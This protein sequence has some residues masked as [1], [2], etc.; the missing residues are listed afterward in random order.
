MI[1]HSEHTITQLIIR[2]EHIRLLQAGPTLLIALIESYIPCHWYAKGCWSITRSCIVCSRETAKPQSQKMGK[3]P[4]KRVT[5]NNIGTVFANVG[6]D[7]AGPAK[8]KY[9]SVRS[10]TV[11]KP[12][13]SVFVSSSVKAVHL[14]VVS[15]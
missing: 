15:D 14:E 4:I 5:P 6:I 10:P 7:Y 9:G 3:L 11:V 12:Y 2:Q 1:L 8:M 13:I